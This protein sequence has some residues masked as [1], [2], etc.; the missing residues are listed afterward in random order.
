MKNNER[1]PAALQTFARLDLLEELGNGER[2]RLPVKRC[3]DLPW[4]PDTKQSFLTQSCG[5][6]HLFE[7]GDQLVT[8][9]YISYVRNERGCM[10]SEVFA[11]AF[12]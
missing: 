1:I 4:R 12:E 11:G 7:Q 2:G 5:I 3:V 6:R 10:E 9:G 8:C